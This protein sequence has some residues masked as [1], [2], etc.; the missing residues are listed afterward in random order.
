MLSFTVRMTFDQADHEDV[1]EM[2]RKLTVESR[3]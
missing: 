2:L 1:A 3:K